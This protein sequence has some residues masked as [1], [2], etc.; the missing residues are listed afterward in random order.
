MIMKITKE[1]LIESSEI[2]DDLLLLTYFYI[3]YIDNLSDIV[4]CL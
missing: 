2:L 3:L 4:D 1:S